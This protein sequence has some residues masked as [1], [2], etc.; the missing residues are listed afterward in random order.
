MPTHIVYSP[1]DEGDVLS[2]T[3]LMSQLNQIRS[4]VNNLP[5][6]ALAPHAARHN[7]LPSLITGLLEAVTPGY[8][9][10]VYTTGARSTYTNRY[11]GYATSTIAANP[12]GSLLG[13]I[14]VSSGGNTLQISFTPLELGMGAA[15]R[16]AGILVRTNITCYS[17]GGAC[18]YWAECEACFC[19]GWMDDGDVWHV[20]PRSERFLN[21]VTTEDPETDQYA[22]PDDYCKYDIPIH[23][24]IDATTIGGG[25]IKAVGVFVARH[26]LG[27]DW[28]TPTAEVKLT[29]SNMSIIPLHAEIL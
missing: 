6:Y 28:A 2:G 24:F 11:P 8:T 18:K 10:A 4:S 23:T 1:Q 16:V 20:I 19:I 7:H 26:D 5:D 14:L 22:Y 21:R 13:W 9:T 29:S 27:A 3:T 12:A 15:G 17:I 25:K